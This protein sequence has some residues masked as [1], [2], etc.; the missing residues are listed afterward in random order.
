MKVGDVSQ[1][2]LPM[3]IRELGVGEYARVEAWR[4]DGAVRPAQPGGGRR[5]PGH[6]SG[7]L[8]SSDARRGGRSGIGRAIDHLSPW[9]LSP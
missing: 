6:L 9:E 7:D 3:R 4:P 1:G 8:L 5:V 2:K